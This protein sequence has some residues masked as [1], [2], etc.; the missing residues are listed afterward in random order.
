MGT[1]L[2]IENLVSRNISPA[3]ND[4]L[5]SVMKSINAIK[6]DAKYDH[7]FKQL[8]EDKKAGH[9]KLTHYTE[10]WWL[11]NRIA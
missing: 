3:F 11:S 8:C 10:V 2:F 7:L 6:D 9:V 1:V 5:K 4:V